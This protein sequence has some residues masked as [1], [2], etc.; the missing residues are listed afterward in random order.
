V[1]ARQSYCEAKGCNDLPPRAHL[2]AH[3]HWGCTGPEHM[4]ALI[5]AFRAEVLADHLPTWE[6]M[7]EPGNVSDYLIGYTQD[8]AGARGAAEAWFRSQSTLPGELAWHEQPIRL[9]DAGFD[10]WLECHRTDPDGTVTD[11][12]MVIRRLAQ[13]PTTPKDTP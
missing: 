1:T 3:A 11:T 8:E 13:Q 12:G 10:R 7:Y 4:A 9:P 5:D 6:V 2:E